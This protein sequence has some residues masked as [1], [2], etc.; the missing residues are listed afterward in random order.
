MKSLANSERQYLEKFV[1]LQAYY[2]LAGRELERELIPLLQNQQLGLL[3][4]NP[5]ACSAGPPS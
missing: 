2:S 1:S 3:V 5:L 4:W